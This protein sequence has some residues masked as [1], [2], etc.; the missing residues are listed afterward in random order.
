[1]ARM[2]KSRVFILDDHLVVLESLKF[3]LGTDSTID[4]VGSSCR[5]DE[6][7]RLIRML[8]PDLVI[9]DIEMP[10]RCVFEMTRATNKALGQGCH[11]NFLFLSAYLSDFYLE[12]ALAVNAMGYI[13][14]N[15]PIATIIEAI[16]TIRRGRPYFSEEVKNR[17]SNK[18]KRTALSQLTARELEVLR[19][20]TRAMTVKDIAQLLGLSSRTIDRHKANIMEKLGIHNQIG[21]VRYAICEGITDRRSI[22]LPEHSIPVANGP[23][24][25][26]TPVANAKRAS[27]T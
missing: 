21:L 23:L 16:H 17:L 8:Q 10:G 24:Y 4:V 2:T 3:L 26:T 18:P 14:K 27:P 7:S 25:P 6:G 13:L 9:V 22:Q 12:K 20:L 1:M 19:Y 5:V 15:H 11:V